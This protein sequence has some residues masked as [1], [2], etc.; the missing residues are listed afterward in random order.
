[1]L[2]ARERLREEL[3][4]LAGLA[5]D[6]SVGDGRVAEAL[7]RV[8]RKFE[9]E[10]RAAGR[11]A[12]RELFETAARELR[13][14]LFAH[15]WGHLCDPACEPYETLEEYL[16][17]ACSYEGAWH[18]HKAGELDHD[19]EHRCGTDGCWDARRGLRRVRGHDETLYFHLLAPYGSQGFCW[20]CV[21]EGDA[22]DQYEYW[23]DNLV[24]DFVTWAE[25]QPCNPFGEARLARSM[26]M[27]DAWALR[28]IAHMLE[29]VH[30]VPRDTIRL[31][32][33]WVVRLA[34]V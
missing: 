28:A 19:D 15:A 25:A 20:A 11:S 1:M 29:T 10:R 33:G 9:E 2:S 26:G 27:V 22:D 21:N 12:D 24:G 5:A 4:G 8:A 18:A 13:A 14:G 23:M 7:A 6:L 31:V 3:I 17:D 30:R 16:S 34:G 32:I